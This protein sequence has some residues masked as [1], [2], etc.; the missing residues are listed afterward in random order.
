M[1]NK[2]AYL[3]I[4]GSFSHTAAIK[5]FPTNSSFIGTE[6][7]RDIFDMIEVG[8][9]KYGAIPIENSLAGSVYE[10]YD[11]LDNYKLYIVGE[12]YIKIEHYLLVPGRNNKT[13]VDLKQIK[14]VYSHQKALEQCGSFF[15]AHPW[16]DKITYSDTANAARFVSHKSDPAIAAIA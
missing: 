6:T 1:L 4:P 5:Y 7:F 16:I 14:K 2:I 12:H 9:A 13:R 3:G 15:K 8:K 11:L 10:N